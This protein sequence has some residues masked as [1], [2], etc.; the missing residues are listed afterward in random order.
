MKALSPARLPWQPCERCGGLGVDAAPDG[1]TLVLTCPG[2]GHEEARRRLPFFSITG[3]SG[4]GKSTLVRRL[5]R[6]LPEC[7]VFDGDVLWH[8]EFWENGQAFCDR[9]LTVAG[10]ASQPGH[11]VVLCTAAMPEAWETEFAVF[12]GEIHVLALIC[13]EEELLGRLGAR[14]RARDDQAPADFLEQTRTFNRVL[15]E[16]LEHVDTSALD[17]DEVAE[18]VAAWIRERL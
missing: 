2:C 8:G 7:V 4:V 16:R 5:W 6:L 12:V 1:P 3:P 18:R 13:D 11:P 10:Q 9:W 15:R 14:V 17:P